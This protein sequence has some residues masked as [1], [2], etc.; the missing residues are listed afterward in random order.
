MHVLKVVFVGEK[1][2]FEIS[3]TQ[4]EEKRVVSSLEYRIADVAH[5]VLKEGAHHHIHYLA[6]LE[7]YFL[8]KSSRLVVLFEVHAASNVLLSRRFVQLAKGLL[9]VFL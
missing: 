9:R 5:Q 7:V 6:N 8:L 2:A 3:K 4:F 1:A